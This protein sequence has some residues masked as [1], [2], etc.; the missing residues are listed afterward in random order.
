LQNEINKSDD[1]KNID[2]ANI[3]QNKNVYFG[4]SF[5][6]GASQTDNIQGIFGRAS[7]QKISHDSKKPVNNAS[8][9]NGSVAPNSH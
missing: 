7:Q 8:P 5:D 1:E 9:N 4:E 2:F 3:L 6:P